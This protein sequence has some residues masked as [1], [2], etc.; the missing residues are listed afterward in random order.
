MYQGNIFNEHQQQQKKKKK[1]KKR[2]P[3]RWMH[4]KK[5]MGSWNNLV[6]S[7]GSSL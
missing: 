2:N 4:L 1:K 7:A 3:G 6:G 5:D